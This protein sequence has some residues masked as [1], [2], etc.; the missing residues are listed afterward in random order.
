MH[1]YVYSLYQWS[2]FLE[3]DAYDEAKSVKVWS[4]AVTHIDITLSCFAFHV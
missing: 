3:H 1:T 4:T 2:S